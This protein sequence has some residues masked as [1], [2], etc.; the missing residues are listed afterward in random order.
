M[1]FCS[2]CGIESKAGSFCSSC[3]TP[4]A[5]QTAA[6]VTVGSIKAMW[7]HLAPLLLAVISTFIALIVTALAAESQ[8]SDYDFGIFPINFVSIVPMS[9]LW[10]PALIV[11]LAPSS[12]PFER[13]H[14]SASLNY[15]ISL[16][17][18]ISVIFLLAIFGTISSFSTLSLNS[19]FNAWGVWA[20]ATIALGVLGILSLVFNIA[21]SSA[22]S[23]GKEYR[24]PIAIKFLK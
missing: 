16:F 10:V 3:G 7:V 4:L 11:R 12:T 2:S 13:R 19:I 23:A 14:A 24:Y 21:G 6:Q 20:L 15:Q 8:T 17:I 5:N 18:Y 22:G 9:I 1:A